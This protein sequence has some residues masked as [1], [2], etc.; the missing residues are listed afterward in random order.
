MEGGN[1]IIPS[2]FLQVSPL[3]PVTSHQSV[4]QLDLIPPSI[5][6]SLN[7]SISLFVKLCKVR[8]K[9]VLKDC[10]N[11]HATSPIKIPLFQR[12]ERIV[13]MMAFFLK[14]V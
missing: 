14:R 8:I 3:L 7:S 2:S 4:I 6:T 13:C 12:N 10:F 5:A 1:L 9:H 11:Q